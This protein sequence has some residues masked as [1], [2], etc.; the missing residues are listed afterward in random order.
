MDFIGG[1]IAG[2]FGLIIVMCV[3]A[4]VMQYSLVF[5]FLAGVAVV[6]YLI[7]LFNTPKESEWGE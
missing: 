2:C 7:Y 5:L 3:L 4:L 1:I 6:G